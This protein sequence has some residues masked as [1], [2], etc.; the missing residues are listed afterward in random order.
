MGS[1]DSS[2]GTIT[3]F[4][5]GTLKV[6]L[7]FLPLSSGQLLGHFSFVPLREGYE[8]RDGETV[9]ASQEAAR[10]GERVYYEEEFQAESRRRSNLQDIHSNVVPQFKTNS[11]GVK[12]G[13][14]LHDSKIFDRFDTNFLNP[15][16]ETRSNKPLEELL[17]EDQTSRIRLLPGEGLPPT[18]PPPTRLPVNRLQNLN[19]PV[20]ESERA[21]NSRL[22]TIYDKKPQRV[23]STSS[24]R[25]QVT[26]F[27]SEPSRGQQSGHFNGFKETRPAATFF[28]TLHS[29]G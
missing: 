6:F 20:K 3:P 17:I 21:K 4:I 9:A 25:E 23:T 26:G 18:P 27:R 29:S 11:H 5:L 13:R 22:G 15:F 12:I 10:L 28:G 8:Y 1:L 14:T 19:K 24:G 2:M 16:T 7:V